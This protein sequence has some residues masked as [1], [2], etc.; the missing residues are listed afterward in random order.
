MI[1]DLFKKAFSQKHIPPSKC[2]W[3]NKASEDKNQAKSEKAG[4]GV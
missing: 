4:G 1:A 3:S 2:E